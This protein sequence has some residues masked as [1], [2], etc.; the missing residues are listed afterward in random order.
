MTEV[1]AQQQEFNLQLADFLAASQQW[2]TPAVIISDGP[3]GLG[4]YP[5]E[6]R[7]HRGLDNWYLPF[8]ERWTEAAASETTLWFWNTEIGWATVHH[9]LEKHGWLYNAANIWDKGLS[10]AAGNTNTQTLRQFPTVTEVCI[11]YIRNPVINRVGQN[12]LTLQEWLR[13]E[14]Q[15]T[16]LSLNQAN[17]ACG[18]RNA[19]T[20]KYLTTCDKW[21][22]PPPNVYQALVDYANQNGDPSGRPYF[23]QQDGTTLP[24]PEYEK[25]RAKFDCP[26]GI[27]NV[28]HH[29]TVPAAERVA[30]AKGQHHP[31]QKP[32]PI[33]EML[34]LASSDPGDIIW[35]PFGGVASV[36]VAA[37]NTGRFCYTTE[38]NPQY[39]EAAKRRLTQR[40]PK[41]PFFTQI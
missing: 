23:A 29:A 8:I 25:L 33:M 19:A 36:A 35:E 38:I 26:I 14:W 37:A 34:I 3:Y 31:N 20:R 21:Y 22:M 24:L 16:G 6:P 28:W 5:G 1:P 41:L 13:A 4:L 39:W 2:P 7:S 18:V 9:Q 10:H 32:L 11:Q 17:K 15:R 40:Q 30:T 12:Q 27:T